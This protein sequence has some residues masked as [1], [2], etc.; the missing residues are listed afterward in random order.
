[1]FLRS[2]VDRER[3]TGGTGSLF[4][5]RDRTREVD[6]VVDTGGHLELLEAKWTELPDAGDTVD[7][8]FV[9]NV[10]GKSRVAAG[11]TVCR[12]PNS[13]PLAN[14]FRALPVTGLR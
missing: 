1:L 8:G 6:F 13:F 12:T 11:A 3:R 2:F 9:R 14:G 10:V 4:F 7:L 5:W